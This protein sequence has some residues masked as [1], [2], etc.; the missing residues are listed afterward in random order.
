VS[1]FR[2]YPGRDG[3][4]SPYGVCTARTLF[5]VIGWTVS[6]NEEYDYGAV[7]LNCTVGNTVGWFPREVVGRAPPPLVFVWS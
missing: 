7:K 6:A 2:I 4:L 3:A 1:S 5:S